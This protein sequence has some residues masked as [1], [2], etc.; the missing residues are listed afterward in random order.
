MESYLKDNWYQ[1][2]E[3]YLNKEAKQKKIKTKVESNPNKEKYTAVKKEKKSWKNHFSIHLIHIYIICRRY[4]ESYIRKES[5]T[6]RQ[7][8]GW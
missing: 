3:T 6:W 5:S 4:Y 1:I 2:E 8:A 7:M